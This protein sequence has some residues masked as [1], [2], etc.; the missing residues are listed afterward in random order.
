MQFKEM[1]TFLS[2]S[3]LGRKK[4]NISCN[5]NF[6]GTVGG[7]CDKISGKCDCLPGWHGISCEKGKKQNY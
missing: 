4:Y 6:N 7:Q 5:C 2:R 3:V 1:P